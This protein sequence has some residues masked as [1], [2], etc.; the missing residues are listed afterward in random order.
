RSHDCGVCSYPSP[1]ELGSAL[2]RRSEWWGGSAS[3]AERGWGVLHLHRAHADTPHPGLR[4]A[5]APSPPLRGGRDQTGAV[6]AVFQK[7]TIPKSARRRERR[8]KPV[9]QLDVDL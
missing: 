4:F 6:D 3:A 9:G 8:L 5:S 2:A 1:R 7:S